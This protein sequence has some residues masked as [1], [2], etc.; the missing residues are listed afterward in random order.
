[1]KK[2]VSNA[3]YVKYILKKTHNSET[4]MDI[5]TPVTAVEFALIT[6]NCAKVVML[7]GNGKQLHSV[8]C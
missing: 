7:L 4:D 8:L 5:C 2:K 1:M 3:T 6:L